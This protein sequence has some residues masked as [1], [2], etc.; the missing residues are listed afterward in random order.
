MDGFAQTLGGESLASFADDELL[1]VLHRVPIPGRLEL[2]QILFLTL[3]VHRRVHEARF[4]H[5]EVDAK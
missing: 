3:A 2:T 1:K 5:H 4:D